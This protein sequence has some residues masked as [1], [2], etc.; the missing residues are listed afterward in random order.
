M[1]Y[2][3]DERVLKE[4][5]SVAIGP[6]VLPGLDDANFCEETP[7]NRKRVLRDGDSW[8]SSKS[9]KTS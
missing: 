6:L 7:Q 9:K 3:M 5:K 2:L 4:G 8:K 1:E